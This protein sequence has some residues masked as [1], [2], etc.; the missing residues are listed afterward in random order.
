VCGKNKVIGQALSDSWPAGFPASKSK[1][2]GVCGRL[3]LAW[4]PQ[5]FPAAQAEPGV[6][7]KED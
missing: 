1:D 3:L 5:V 6:L 7:E 2:R 4:L